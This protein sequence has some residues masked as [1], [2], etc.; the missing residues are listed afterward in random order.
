MPVAFLRFQQ[1]QEEITVS[2]LQTV[3]AFAKTNI[4]LADGV[5][6]IIL[7]PR[8]YLKRFSNQ[9]R[10]RL[11]DPR[12]TFTNIYLKNGWGG[13]ESV[14]GPGSS[15]QAVLQVQAALEKLVVELQVKSI[16]D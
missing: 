2:W 13:S 12:D 4:P 6:S 16:L 11:Q 9:L 1:S 7:H 3:K 14:S 15:M 10:L 8:H 5:H